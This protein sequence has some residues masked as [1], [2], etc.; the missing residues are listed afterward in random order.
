VEG[1][2]ACS[3]LEIAEWLMKNVIGFDWWGQVLCATNCA[4]GA[5]FVQMIV[6]CLTPSDVEAFEWMKPLHKRRMSEKLFEHFVA[7]RLVVTHSLISYDSKEGTYYS[8]L[9]NATAAR[10]P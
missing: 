8:V 10:C 2:D 6:A 1:R 4:F 9:A 3:I 7:G 5:H